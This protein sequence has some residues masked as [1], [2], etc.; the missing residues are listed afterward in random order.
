M[1]AQAAGHAAYRLEVFMQVADF[2]LQLTGFAGGLIAAARAGE[3]QKAQFLL[4]MLQGLLDGGLV[5][6]QQ[7][8]RSTE[9]AGLQ[10]RLEYLDVT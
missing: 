4:G 8:R 5:H 6:V 2:Y 10:D 3:Q 9:V 7:L 1:L